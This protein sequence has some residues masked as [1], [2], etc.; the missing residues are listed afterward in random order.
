MVVSHAVTI[1]TFLYHLHGRDEE[2][3]VEHYQQNKLDNCGVVHFRYNPESYLH[4]DL[5]LWNEVFW[6]D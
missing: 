6:K 1:A 3:T 4:W 5:V 2:D